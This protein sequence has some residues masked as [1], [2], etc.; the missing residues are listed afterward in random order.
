V[1]GELLG[2][3]KG[4]AKG[5]AEGRSEIDDLIGDFFAEAAG[6]DGALSIE[7]EP[8]GITAHAVQLSVLDGL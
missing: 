2:A 5:R 8:T 1:I 7:A 3:A 6:E 4:A